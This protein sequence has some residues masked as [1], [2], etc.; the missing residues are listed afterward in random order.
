MEFSFEEKEIQKENLTIEL[1]RHTYT[2]E[3]IELTKDFY[4]KM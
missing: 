3:Y 2:K 1:A 4:L